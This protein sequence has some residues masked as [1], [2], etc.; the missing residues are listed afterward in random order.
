MSSAKQE[1][2]E[3]E[4]EREREREREG[5]GGGERQV[6]EKMK[7]RSMNTFFLCSFLNDELK[8]RFKCSCLDSSQT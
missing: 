5:G 1:E 2:R 4:R 6:R 8:I 3:K 7:D